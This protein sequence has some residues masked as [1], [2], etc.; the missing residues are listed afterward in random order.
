MYGLSGAG[1][2]YTISVTP[3]AVTATA[4]R[5]GSFGPISGNS[6][7]MD[8]DPVNDNIRFSSDTDINDRISPTTGL[9]LTN[10]PNLSYG[11]SQNP[12]IVGLAY[13]NSKNPAPA[14]TTLYGID[15][16][17][18]SLVQVESDQQGF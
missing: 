8:V 7:G 12:S 6:T 9:L 17:S 15:S 4:V 16:V 13:T 2:V 3:A 18:D 1:K 10:T 5:T 14:S 11:T